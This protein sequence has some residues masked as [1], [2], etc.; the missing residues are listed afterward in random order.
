MR[1]LLRLQRVYSKSLL[2]VAGT[3]RRVRASA[4]SRARAGNSGE[5]PLIGTLLSTRPFILKAATGR[6]YAMRMRQLCECP[7]FA[8]GASGRRRAA[9]V[10]YVDWP[11]MIS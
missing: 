8:K 1:S 6:H 3:A 9:N 2:M 11:D 4:P 10:R 5:I 7:E